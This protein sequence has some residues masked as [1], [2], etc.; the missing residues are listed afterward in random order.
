MCRPSFQLGDKMFSDALVPTKAKKR[1]QLLNSVGGGLIGDWASEVPLKVGRHSAG[2][3]WGPRDLWHPSEAELTR[4]K[5]GWWEPALS[6]G[7]ARDTVAKMPAG[8]RK[9]FPVSFKH[10]NMH[11]QV[12]TL[13]YPTLWH[14]SLVLEGRK[15]KNILKDY[16]RLCRLCWRPDREV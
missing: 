6:E 5:R 1:A 16:W 9:T 8:L 11:W 7:L 3:C 12:L 4:F 13:C 2:L 10:K 14:Y 15:G